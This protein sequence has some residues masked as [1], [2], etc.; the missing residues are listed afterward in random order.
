[1]SLSGLAG[2]LRAPG[3][4]R[5]GCTCLMWVWPP[6]PKSYGSGGHSKDFCSRGIPGAALLV[7]SVPVLCPLSME[8]EAQGVPWV[9]KAV[10]GFP[11]A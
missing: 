6:A 5:A 11:M 1:M 9:R 7:S 4:C 10:R 3:S 2:A 8:T